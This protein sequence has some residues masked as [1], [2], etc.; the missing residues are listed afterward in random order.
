MMRCTA[1]TALSP[2]NSGGPLVDSNTVIGVNTAIIPMALGICFAIAHNIM[3]CLFKTK[4]C[5]GADPFPFLTL[6]P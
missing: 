1:D 2:G 4:V 3:V 5:D 6:H